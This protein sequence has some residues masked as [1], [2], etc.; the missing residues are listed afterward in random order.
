MRKLLALAAWLALAANLPAADNTQTNPQTLILIGIDGLRADYLDKY[1]PEN[2]TRLAK[3]GVRAER[4]IP[5]FPTLT[6]PNFYTLATGLYPGHHG[7][8]NNTMYDAEFKESFRIGQGSVGA[9]DG[10]WWEGEPIWVTAEKQG[11]R[12]ACMFWPGTE[13][14][15]AGVRP[16]TWMPYIESTKSEFRVDT[17][18]EWL[19]APP[20]QRPALI[21]LYFHQV[22]NTGHRY[23]PDTPEVVTAL[24]EV[25]AAI[26]RLL[27]GIEKLKL[28]D[29]TNLIIVS[30]HGMAEVSPERTIPL[31]DYIARDEAQAD[32]TGA[33]AGLR[34]LKGTPA[35]L[36][37]KFT[38][39]ENHFRAYLR[40]NIPEE[41]HY[42]DHRRI[43]PVI[44]IADEGWHITRHKGLDNLL[45]LRPMKGAHGFDPQ[46]PS[47]GATFIAEGPAF[48]KGVVLPPFE[49]VHI[50]NLLC[51]VMGLKPAKNDGDQ[52]LLDQVLA[53]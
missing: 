38:G 40:E 45:A 52:R 28:T 20:E 8:V 44:L 5:S 49:N 3:E 34:P 14:E 48:R 10:R 43:P 24:K 16:S 9:T 27:E 46:A 12:A 36:L 22:D 7:I 25:D 47:M 30:D 18:L 32:F 1:Q 6:F 42:R 39:K 53:K 2:L 23:G 35:E 26:G 17:V 37:A 13:A 50:Y 19:A 51:A 29:S 4:M 31:S 15:I 11:R 33:V 41:Y 21:T